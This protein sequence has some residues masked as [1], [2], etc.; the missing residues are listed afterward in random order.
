[1]ESG[2]LGIIFLLDL[3]I[4]KVDFSALRVILFAEDQV[5][6]EIII[7]L[8]VEISSSILLHWKKALV[9]S[10]KILKL[11]MGQQFGRSLMNI[12][13]NRGP[14]TDPWGHHMIWSESLIFH[15]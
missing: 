10:A 2:R 4:V 13:N 12:K 3:K 5:F 11:P 14:R 9:S 1:M 6:S 8:P 15:H 7:N